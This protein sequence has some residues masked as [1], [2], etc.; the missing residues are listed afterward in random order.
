MSAVYK[1]V[2]C[3]AETTTYLLCGKTTSTRYAR[4]E[5]RQNVE[6][7]SCSKN[8]NHHDHRPQKNRILDRENG[9]KSARN[10]RGEPASD[11]RAYVASHHVPHVCR[12]PVATNAYHAQSCCD[13]G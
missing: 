5:Q 3:Q 1:D 4:L 7:P 6:H 12:Y 11:Q 8:H 2:R 10:E 13:E 9:N